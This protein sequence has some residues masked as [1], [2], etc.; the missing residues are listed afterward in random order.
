[1]LGQRLRRWPNIEPTLDKCTMFERKSFCP[2]NQDICMTFMQCRPN[3]FDVGPT[4]HK[5]IRMFCVYWVTIQTWSSSFQIP[6][7]IQS[8]CLQVGDQVGAK[9]KGFELLLH[10]CRSSIYE[11]LWFESLLLMRLWVLNAYL[12]LLLNRALAYPPALLPS[13]GPL[14]REFWQLSTPLKPGLG[15]WELL[16]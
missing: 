7:V 13:G 6:A 9:D 10:R 1:M 16:F 2:A 15:V 8:V 4:L 11:L 3:V 5:V 14:S 12:V